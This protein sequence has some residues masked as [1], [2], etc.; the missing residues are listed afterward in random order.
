ML[1]YIIGSMLSASW[2]GQ[3]WLG[4]G[5]IRRGRGDSP[6]LPALSSLNYLFPLPRINARQQEGKTFMCIITVPFSVNIRGH[7]HEMGPPR[8][9]RRIL[10]SIIHEEGPRTRASTSAPRGNKTV[11]TS[12]RPTLFLSLEVTRQRTSVV[13]AFG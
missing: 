12:S 6:V 10:A 3:G 5:E 13:V 8:G 11:A 7:Y 4:Q 1:S 2:L 9:P